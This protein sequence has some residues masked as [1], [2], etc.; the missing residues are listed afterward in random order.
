[1]SKKKKKIVIL[2]SIFTFLASIFA[3]ISWNVSIYYL[4]F[5]F[6]ALTHSLIQISRLT[7][8]AEMCSESERA[9]YVALT[10]IITVPFLLS[11]ILAGWIAQLFNY[12]TVFVICA[13]ISL[14]VVILYFYKVKEPRHIYKK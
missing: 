9:I 12:N 8:I 7:I 5:I 11:N 13:V 14:F 10:N 2:T 4:V 3:V 1:M 6:S